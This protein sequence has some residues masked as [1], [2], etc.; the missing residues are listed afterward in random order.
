ML[1]KTTIARPYARAAF[2]V[3]A[4]EDAFKSWSELLHILALAVA[5]PQMSPLLH[6]PR[7]SDE[8]LLDIVNSL[9][10][11]AP[12]DSQQ[13]FIRLLIDNGR[14][15]YA[16][17][18]EELFEQSRLDAEGMARVN[19][20]AAHSLESAQKEKIKAAM[21]KRL[22]KQIELSAETDEKLIGGAVIRY[23]DSVIDASIRGQLEA[24]RNQLL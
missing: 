18:I 15:Q 6:N 7:V 3:A 14:L 12:G 16:T 21:T 2:E 1:E 23:G 4:E 11:Q 20:I 9:V 13:R 5:D 24:L 19:V 17:Q 22:D 10:G 8:Q